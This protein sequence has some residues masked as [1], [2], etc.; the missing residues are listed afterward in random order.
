[1]DSHMRAE[2]P[3]IAELLFDELSVVYVLGFMQE[4]R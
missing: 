3:R 2:D 4:N 1:M